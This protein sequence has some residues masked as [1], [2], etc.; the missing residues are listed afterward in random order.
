MPAKKTSSKTP[1]S[2][3]AF[4]SGVIVISPRT[5]GSRSTPARISP[6]M[7]GRP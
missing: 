2:A 4:N 1:R 6:I 3:M 7:D 5:E